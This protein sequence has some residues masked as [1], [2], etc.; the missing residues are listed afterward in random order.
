M[1]SNLIIDVGFNTGQNTEFYLKKGFRVIAIEALPSVY[2]ST[3]Q[4]LNSCIEKASRC[5]QS[6]RYLV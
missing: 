3:R 2:E 6:Q 1:N 4:R 5:N